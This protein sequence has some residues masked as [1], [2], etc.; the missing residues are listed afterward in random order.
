MASGRLGYKCIPP[1]NSCEI[2]N[3]ASGS[4][5]SITVSAQS[6]NSTADNNVSLA[7]SDSSVCLKTTSNVATGTNCFCNTTGFSFNDTS[8]YQGSYIQSACYP[9]VNT[10]FSCSSVK[11][12]AAPTT[13][14]R[15]GG[16]EFLLPG[17]DN[18][19]SIQYSSVGLASNAFFTV[20]CANH[21]YPLLITN[22]HYDDDY[23]K[24]GQVFANAHCNCG[25]IG[26]PIATY[27][28]CSIECASLAVCYSNTNWIVMWN[29]YNVG[30]Y[31]PASLAN[32]CL[33]TCT[34]NCLGR[35]NCCSLFDCYWNQ[36]PVFGFSTCAACV[37]CTRAVY[38]YNVNDCRC[39]TCCYTVLG[40]VGST[41]NCSTYCCSLTYTLGTYTTLLTSIICNQQ[42]C[43][44]DTTAAMSPYGVARAA[45][46][47]LY[48]FAATND[49]SVSTYLIGSPHYWEFNATGNTCTVRTTNIFKIDSPNGCEYPIKWVSHDPDTENS[50]FM[51]RSRTSTNCG[52]FKYCWQSVDPTSCFSSYPC[53][54]TNYLLCYTDIASHEYMTKVASF[55][56]AMTS[57]AYTSPVMCVGCLFRVDSSNWVISVWNNTTNV[58]DRF[59]SSNLIDWSSVGTTY[60]LNKT[61]TQSYTAYPSCVQLATNN[62]EFCVP[63][64]GYIDYQ[65]SANNFE[66]TGVVISNGDRVI[67]N[68]DS[69]NGLAVQVW[70][71]EG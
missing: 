71:Y 62:Y 58:W 38:S 46:Y 11:T 53:H 39:S 69:A 64:C 26:Y 21:S 42:C 56:S 34:G 24:A 49:N 29:N 13:I 65:V 12:T 23:I 25:T 67:V 70:G 61:N 52:I 43:N 10:F 20:A 48:A 57:S 9:N 44:T 36:L 59:V 37:Q 19:Q 16:S 7:I 68:N 27:G 15:Y 63:Q 33:V 41:F 22:Y 32:C 55:P 47:G 8:T 50:Y 31:Q 5:A 60:T 35:V 1:Y 2:Y 66:R 51:V 6:L 3:N 45:T 18:I 17:V 4:P 40:Q 30:M 28:V 54:C 14:A